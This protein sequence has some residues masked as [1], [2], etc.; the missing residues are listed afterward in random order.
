MNRLIKLG[1][2]FCNVYFKDV[3]DALTNVEGVKA[4]DLKSINGHAVVTVDSSK[5]EPEQIATAVSTVKS[6]SWYSTGR[7]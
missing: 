7:S 2:K 4:I 3:R 5:V 6:D 1:G